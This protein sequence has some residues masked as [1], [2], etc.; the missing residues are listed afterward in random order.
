MA[1]HH[2]I[3]TV[4]VFVPPN[5]LGKTHICGVPD[6]NY[7]VYCFTPTWCRWVS[8]RAAFDMERD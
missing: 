2:E 6:N 8:D 7:V 5:K 1:V 4:S 3:L